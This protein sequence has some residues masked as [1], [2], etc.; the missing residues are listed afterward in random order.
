MV[1]SLILKEKCFTNYCFLDTVFVPKHLS[2]RVKISLPAMNNDWVFVVI[3]C[4]NHLP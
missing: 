1:L 4:F 2:K 3:T